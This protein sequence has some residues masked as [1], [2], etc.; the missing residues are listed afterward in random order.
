MSVRTLPHPANT[1]ASA[2]ESAKPAPNLVRK[3]L[4]KFG[5]TAPMV[6]QRSRDA[7]VIQSLPNIVD[8]E[9]LDSFS[10]EHSIPMDRLIA[11][12]RNKAL[13]VMNRI[14]GRTTPE[15]LAADLTA[16]TTA[17]EHVADERTARAILA[18]MLDGL[19]AAGGR[20]SQTLVDAIAFE[21]MHD[22]D[23][24]P[25]KYSGYAVA[26]AMRAIWR[27]KTFAPSIREIIEAI[28]IAQAAIRD[29]KTT[30]ATMLQHW[31]AA[32]ALLAATDASV[33]D[34]S[35]IPF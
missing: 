17:F 4:D 16:L 14:G 15:D 11:R 35:E 5:T 19:P 20:L 12:E 26:A 9:R 18:V 2:P 10:A 8:P 22:A 3:V 29:A 1:P 34:S 13:D 7:V 31:Q 21:V 33:D 23:G 27:Q 30:T 32:E 28:E 6:A 25:S 24:R